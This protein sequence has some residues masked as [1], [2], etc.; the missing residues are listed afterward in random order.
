[1]RSEEE[2]RAT[3]DQILEARERIEPRIEEK[4]WILGR[5]DPQYFLDLQKYIELT[6]KANALRFVL[7]EE[8][9]DR[10]AYSPYWEYQN[11]KKKK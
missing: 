10:V 9:V 3:I 5:K 11:Q 6:E 4:D 2:I 7:E 8:G 1:V